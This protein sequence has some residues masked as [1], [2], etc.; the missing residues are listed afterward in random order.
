[1][2]LA[3]TGAMAQQ[4][5]FSIEVRQPASIDVPGWDAA[6]TLLLVNNS[7]PQPASF[8]HR[9]KMND[10]AFGD[11]E[12]DLQAGAR[13]LLFGLYV[14]LGNQDA[15]PEVEL[16]DRSQHRTG[17]FYQRSSLLKASCDSLLNLYGA[18]ALLILN[19][20]VIYDMQESYLTEDDNYY[21]YLEAYCSS[22]WTYYRQGAT[23]ASFTYSDTLVWS[24]TALS[25]S[26]ALEGLPD[27]QQ[28]LLDL[29][30]DAG[31]QLAARFY[32]TWQREDR[33]VY[34]T[35]G[36]ELAEGMTLFAQQKWAEAEAAWK[37]AYTS[38][39]NRLTRAY[40]L[41]NMAVASEMQEQFGRAIVYLKSAEEEL[42]PVRTSESR[43]QIINLRYYRSQLSLRSRK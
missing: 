19:Q 25:P 35:K 21:A 7:V 28:A 40:A 11:T 32:P 22:H 24:N 17:N 43:Q 34:E 5:Y 20:V 38:N 10:V 36:G 6:T 2:L 27:R 41:A 3:L 14:G 9:N 31:E 26:T 4:R 18:D 39:S 33:Y 37:T 15:A 42:L 1:L 16:L 30:A 8:G 13:H 23:P 29:A 12:L